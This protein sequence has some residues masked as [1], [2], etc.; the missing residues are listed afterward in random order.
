MKIITQLEH[1][2]SLGELARVLA[3]SDPKEFAEFWFIF[4]EV[5][6][7]QKLK[8]FAKEMS[9]QLGSIRKD[10]FYKL[11]KYIRYY[12]VKEEMEKIN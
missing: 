9:P 12:E 5:V 1:E 8:D 10:T 4:A 6:D 3:K 11:V 7:K 2:F